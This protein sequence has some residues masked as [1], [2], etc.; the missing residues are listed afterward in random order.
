MKTVTYDP[1]IYRLAPIE[2]S[3]DMQQ[4][5]ALAIRFD[6]TAINKIWTG[7]KVYRAMLAAMPDDLPGVTTHSGEPVGYM[8]PYARI[9]QDGSRCDEGEIFV[10]ASDVGPYEK[11]V[12]FPLFTHPAPDALAIIK[13]TLEAAIQAADTRSYD[14]IRAIDPQ[15]IL[16]RMKP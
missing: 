1:A 13:A 8:V 16:D 10:D 14:A 2:P 15:S 6:T 3:D 9:E 11:K 12:G 4:D 5:G 7:N